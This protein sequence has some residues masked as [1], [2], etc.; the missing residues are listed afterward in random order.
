MC[1]LSRVHCR[2]RSS[3]VSVVWVRLVQACSPPCVSGDGFVSCV[4]C[5]FG[6]ACALGLFIQSVQVGPSFE[7]LLAHTDKDAS[8]VER[9][10]HFQHNMCIQLDDAPYRLQI[11]VVLVCYPVLCILRETRTWIQAVQPLTR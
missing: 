8:C 11:L 9:H 3:R 10:I 2:A 5:P 7:W 4:L 6:V 1:W